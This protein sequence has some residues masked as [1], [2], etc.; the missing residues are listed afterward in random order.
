MR[1]NSCISVA[2]DANIGPAVFGLAAF[3][4]DW[5]IIAYAAFKVLVIVDFVLDL[6]P[7]IYLFAYLDLS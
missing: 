4:F 7:E 1:T 3:W 5:D 6:F 2:N